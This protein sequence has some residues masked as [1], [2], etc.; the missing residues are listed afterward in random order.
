MGSF[1]ND[2]QPAASRFFSSASGPV[3]A[4]C[5]VHVVGVHHLAVPGRRMAEKDISGEETY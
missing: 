2:P 5:V 4:T 3:L 1:G